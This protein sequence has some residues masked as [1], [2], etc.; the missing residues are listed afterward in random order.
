M[1]RVGGGGGT[2]RKGKSGPLWW[3]SMYLME[4]SLRRIRA[5]LWGQRG[6]PGRQCFGDPPPGGEGGRLTT[7]LGGGG[8][9]GPGG[10]WVP[11]WG[12][13]FPLRGQTFF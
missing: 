3:S 7:R 10:C 2:R 4:D 8:V 6:A 13:V 9:S 12:S 1:A 11:A 5:L